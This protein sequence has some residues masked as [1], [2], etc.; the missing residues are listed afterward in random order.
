MIAAIA[1]P[2]ALPH[3]FTTF[4]S[5]AH[6]NNAPPQL[7]AIFSKAVIANAQSMR[8]APAV[9]PATRSAG[10]TI[11]LGEAVLGKGHCISYIGLIHPLKTY[12]QK[13]HRNEDAIFFNPQRNFFGVIDGLGGKPHGDKAARLCADYLSKTHL[14]QKLPNLIHNLKIQLQNARDIFEGAGCCIAA[15]KILHENQQSFLQINVVGDCKVLVLR[16][17]QNTHEIL[18]NSDDRLDKLL[19]SVDEKTITNAE[20]Q[21]YLNTRHKVDGCVKKDLL[22]H[23]RIKHTEQLIFLQAKDWV[24]LMTDGVSDNLSSQELI[25]TIHTIATPDLTPKALAQ[26]IMQLVLIRQQ[27][28]AEML[29]D[30]N[31]DN[32]YQVLANRDYDSKQDNWMLTTIDNATLMIYQQG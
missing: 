14:D 18:F 25:K 31:F 29:S 20:I 9:N 12:D 7:K 15:A 30:S 23:I 28:L 11:N 2:T 5:R 10:F 17:Q 8:Q 3:R 22:H 27:K 16:P 19:Y 21:H 24:I 1:K 6:I 4:F 32:L 13:P 26:K